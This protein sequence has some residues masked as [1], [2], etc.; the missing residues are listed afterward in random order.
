MAQLDFA[1]G[2]LEQIKDWHADVAAVEEGVEGV[3][4]RV[5]SVV[6]VLEVLELPLGEQARHH[7]R[8]EHDQAPVAQPV[9]PEAP[10]PDAAPE[11]SIVG[12]P[13]FSRK[14][15][16]SFNWQGK[17]DYGLKNIK[18]ELELSDEQADGTG[19]MAMYCLNLLAIV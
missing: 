14:G 17:D 4:R 9:A 8:D 10:P 19:W 18:A 12:Q 5:P 1:K 16:F 2:F 13:E 15:T 3:D 7:H 6:E 11:V